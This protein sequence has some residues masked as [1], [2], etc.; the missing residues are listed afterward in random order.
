M[1]I[2]SGDVITSLILLID[3]QLVDAKKASLLSAVIKQQII[4]L[5]S[6]S[7]Q[8]S[9]AEQGV[10]L[11]QLESTSKKINTLL[12][13]SG[14]EQSYSGM[15]SLIESNQLLAHSQK[16]S[17]FKKLGELK[18]SLS[19][20]QLDHQVNQRLVQQGHQI[21][22]RALNELLGLDTGHLTRSYA[23]SYDEFGNTSNN[24]F[25]KTFASV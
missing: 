6:S 2:N 23:D 24:A 20:N 10:T 15:T 11:E 9:F 3:T 18:Q 16:L 17:L 1:S 12:T 7:L 21:A 19:Q 22:Q 13:T 8:S 14:V 5:D 4:D 25:P